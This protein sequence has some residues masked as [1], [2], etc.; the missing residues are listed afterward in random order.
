MVSE[1]PW[2]LVPV[3]PQFFSSPVTFGG[4]CVGFTAGAKGINKCMS[5]CSEQNEG[6]I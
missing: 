3:G 4:Q 6:Q 5:C 2:V 1:T